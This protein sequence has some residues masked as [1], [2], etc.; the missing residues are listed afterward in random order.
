MNTPHT[1]STPDLELSLVTSKN[2][3][4][5]FHIM[6]RSK[7]YG[8]VAHWIIVAIALVP[9]ILVQQVTRSMIE[10]ISA[11]II[12]TDSYH[13]LFQPDDNKTL[14]DVET[15]EALLS[16][17]VLDQ[18]VQSAHVEIR[19][20]GLIRKGNVKSGISIRGIS[21]TLLQDEG[22]LHYISLIEGTMNFKNK[23]EV[24][25]GNAVAKKIGASLGDTILM[26]TTRSDNISSLPKISRS[27][28]V[29]IISTGYEEL[30]KTWV[31]TPL[32]KA[33]SIIPTID[34]QW[35]IGIKIVDPFII[36]NELVQRSS[37]QQEYGNRIMARLSAIILQKG[38]LYTWY[39]LNYNRYLLFEETKRLLSL[40]MMIAVVLA[41]VTLSSTM[42]MKVIDMEPDIAMLKGMGA[43]P[44]LLE[45]QIF[46][47]GLRYGAISSLV[48]VLVGMLLTFQINGIIYIIDTV[49]N[50][51]RWII[52]F[53]KPIS[54]LNPQ[55]YLSGVP[56]SFYPL[57]IL[58]VSVFAIVLSVLAA[59]APARRLRKISALKIIR[60]H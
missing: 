42:S 8:R 36:S 60:R 58:W 6:W 41:A 51:L 22:F 55:Y 12:E 28:V 43:S 15:R 31:I 45:R 44:R 33:Q 21:D 52:G 54:I 39:S 23:D 37:Q 47:E 3:Y 57:D 50:R 20:V 49:I 5:F 11:R 27:K 53:T 46:L 18:D 10:G 26:L 14:S 40:V 48:G 17:L 38:Q 24:L 35:F 34:Q 32:A 1:F 56:F 19:G 25:L 9:L 16:A 13:I 2:R 4:H 29:G 7:K 30:D 59:W